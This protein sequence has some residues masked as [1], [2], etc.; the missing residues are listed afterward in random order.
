[1]KV[2]TGQGL[3]ISGIA[4]DDLQPGNLTPLNG[5]PIQLNHAESNISFVKDICH[6]APGQPETGD[7]NVTRRTNAGGLL[8]WTGHKLLDGNASVSQIFPDGNLGFD[9]CDGF[10]G[11][12]NRDRCGGVEYGDGGTGRLLRAAVKR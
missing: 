2:G 3:S 8:L 9:G 10:T 12:A 11:S 5:R 1:M 7:N 6:F 4:F